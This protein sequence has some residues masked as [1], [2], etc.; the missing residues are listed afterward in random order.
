M[1]CPFV[2]RFLFYF[3]YWSMAS[4][5]PTFD[6]LRPLHEC[7]RTLT[8]N[9]LERLKFLPVFPGKLSIRHYQPLFSSMPGKSALDFFLILRLFFCFFFYFSQYHD[10]GRQNT[11]S[12]WSIH[13]W[14]LGF[15][16]EIWTSGCLLHFIGRL[17]SS[18]W[19]TACGHVYH[20]IQC[21]SLA[22][23]LLLFRGTTWALSQRYTIHIEDFHWWAM[24]LFELN[25]CSVGILPTVWW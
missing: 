22:R 15:V 5:R 4:S 23:N 19:P 7:S 3:T 14:S 18:G 17:S 20:H 25:G 9:N 11:A 13:S 12:R 16:V 6:H 8:Q 21:N 1:Y 2:C 10:T 24:S